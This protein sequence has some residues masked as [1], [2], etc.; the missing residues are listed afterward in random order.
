[1]ARRLAT[2]QKIARSGLG[3]PG[4]ATVFLKWWPNYAVA[5]KMQL[6]PGYHACRTSNSENRPPNGIMIPAL[7][8]SD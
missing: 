1:M 2:N 7:Y 8:T 6:H 4:R 3:D 5:Q